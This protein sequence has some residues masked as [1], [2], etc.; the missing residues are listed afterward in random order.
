MRR[1]IPKEYKDLAL[2]LSLNEGLSDHIIRDYIGISPRAMR[3]LRQ[4]FRET[5][6]TVR[7]PVVQGRP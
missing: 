1:H 2:H 3:R 4:T 6:E 7:V 5:G